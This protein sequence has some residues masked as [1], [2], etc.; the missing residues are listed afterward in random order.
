MFHLIGEL[1]SAISSRRAGKVH[2]CTV[3]SDSYIVGMLAKKMYIGDS[4]SEL[5]QKNRDP[6]STRYRF[7]QAL[8]ELIAINPE[9]RSTI[10]YVVNTVKDKPYYMEEP[11]MCY[12]Q[13]T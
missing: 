11:S 3:L 4:T 5:F 10:V 9:E 8:K 1:G 13:S 12:C 2:A 7:E 6:T